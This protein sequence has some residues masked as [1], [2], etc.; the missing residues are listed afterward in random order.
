MPIEGKPTEIQVTVPEFLKAYVAHGITTNTYSLNPLVIIQADEM[1]PHFKQR[2][3]FE[4]ARSIARLAQNQLESACK[5]YIDAEVERRLTEL[6]E[7]LVPPTQ[8]VAKENPYTSSPWA[9]FFGF[10]RRKKPFEH[11]ELRQPAILEDKK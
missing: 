7:T 1:G 2:F 11:A 5:E 4:N 9:R 6:R 8:P 10:G 3:I